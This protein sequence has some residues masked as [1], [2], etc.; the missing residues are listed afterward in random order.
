MKNQQAGIF[1]LFSERTT[2]PTH[3]AVVL[4]F[5]DLF[6]FAFVQELAFAK[7]SLKSLIWKPLHKERVFDDIDDKL[8]HEDMIHP[9]LS[10]FA[11]S[12]HSIGRKAKKKIRRFRKSLVL[13]Q[14]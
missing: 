7:I 3:I 12:F 14:M 8:L 2:P 6:S 13:D 10:Y 11:G 4:K 1:C 9:Q 5:T